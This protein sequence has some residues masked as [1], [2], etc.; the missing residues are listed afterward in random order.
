MPRSSCGH[1]WG[2]GL[3]LRGRLYGIGAGPALIF[4]L[5]ARNPNSHLLPLSTKVRPKTTFM[6]V[7]CCQSE[8]AVKTQL[9][10]AVSVYVLIAILKKRLACERI[11]TPSC[12]C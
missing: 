6:K 1:I 8:N 10:I 7:C 9:W 2:A 5:A 12:K 11:C 3:F 4:A